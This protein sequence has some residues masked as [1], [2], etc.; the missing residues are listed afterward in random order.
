MIYVF[1]AHS[2]DPRKGPVHTFQTRACFSY[3]HANAYEDGAGRIVLDLVGYDD[4]EIFIGE[5]G[6]A[7]TY[8]MGD[9]ATRDK[10]VWHAMA[11]GRFG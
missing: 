8:N 2:D 9:K 6:F 10:Q 7:Y 3:H 11:F 4:A 5:H 1:D